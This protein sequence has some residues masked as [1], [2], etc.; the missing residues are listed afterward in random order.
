MMKPQYIT[1]T[2][3][4]DDTSVQEMEALSAL[5]PV[6]WGVLF[7][8]S[9][10][11]KEPRYP[12][13]SGIKKL[14]QYPDR[15]QLRLAA[16]LCGEYSRHIMAGGRPEEG[17]PV[18]LDD[19]DRIQINHADPIPLRLAEFADRYTGRVI[20]QAR[21]QTWPARW[22][23]FD[24]LFDT[25]GGR[26]VEPKEWPRHP[27]YWVGY[28]GGITPANVGEVITKIAATKPYW[29]DMESGVRTNDVFDLKKCRA[30]CEAVFGRRN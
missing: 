27:G 9:R 26:G 3:Y 11:G 28:A 15:N 8:A 6:E 29:I 2:G 23:Q 14:M 10:Q 16:H 13:V 4:D 18:G 24:Y 25:S 22:G 1:F 20:T 21:G 12:S 7:S 30:V 17:L 5:Y 19:F